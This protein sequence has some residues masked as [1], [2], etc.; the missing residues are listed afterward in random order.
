MNMINDKVKAKDK[1]FYKEHK[2][3]I[4]EKKLYAKI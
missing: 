2:Q 1:K 4:S 3:K